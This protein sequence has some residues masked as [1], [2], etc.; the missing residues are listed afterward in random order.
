MRKYA[1]SIM[2]APVAAL[3]L[4]VGATSA[5]GSR[6]DDIDRVWTAATATEADQIADVL[7]QT[8]HARAV[9][10]RTF[11]VSGIVAN[12][13]DDPAVPLTQQQ[14]ATLSRINP[15]AAPKGQLTAELAFYARWKQGDAAF[16]RV[17]SA[18]RLGV[19]ADPTDLA[20]AMPKRSDPIYD[21]PLIVH[22]V[23]ISGDRAYMEAET[24][25]VYYRVTLVHR[26]NR[27][28]IAGENNTS[29]N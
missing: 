8:M 25:P 9:A 6:S 13:V 26:G 12:V 4:F 23:V 7:W 10:A 14:T 15:A 21:L 29:R 27:W 19:A 1:L 22:S 5:L 18:R 24:G 20:A 28:F 17:Q 2:L 11:D 16:T 3:L